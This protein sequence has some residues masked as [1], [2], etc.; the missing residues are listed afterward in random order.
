MAKRQYGGY[1]QMGVISKAIHKWEAI[2]SKAIHKWEVI[3]SKAI[4]KWEAHHTNECYPQMGGYHQPEG[5]PQMGGHH[6]RL[7]TNGRPSPEAI[8]KWEAI[9]SRAI[10]KMGGYQ[11]SYAM[12]GHHY[13]GR[14]RKWVDMVSGKN[15]KIN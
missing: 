15:N 9:T 13:A 12:G 14:I 6:H 11:Q 7:S 1:P 10:R 3:T 5:Y 4:H 8:H 2:T